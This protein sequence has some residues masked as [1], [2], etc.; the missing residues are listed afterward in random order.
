MYDTK[1]AVGYYKVYPNGASNDTADYPDTTNVQNIMDYA[2][3]PVMFTH[4]QVDRMRSALK[5]SVGNRDNLI[6]EDNL[7]IT[8]VMTAAGT[9]A[10]KVDMKPVAEYSVEKVIG[11]SPERSYFMC[12]DDAKLF[13]FKNQSWRDT[14]T[15]ISWSF[16]NGATPATCLLYT[17]R[18]V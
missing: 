6:K 18:C 1:C 13:N 17:S 4:Q 15:S 12:A 3:C 5:S 9:M 7:K 2:D 16:S 8:G 10:P 14:I 11:V